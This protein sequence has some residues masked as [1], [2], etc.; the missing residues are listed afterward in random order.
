MKRTDRNHKEILDYCRSR[1]A[2]V[3]ST[4][5]LGKGFPDIVMGYKGINYLLE[6]KDGAKPPSQRKL[7]LDEEAFHGKWKGMLHIIKSTSDIDSIIDAVS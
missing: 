3:Y 7:T 5:A 4:H 2:S 1:G 6:V